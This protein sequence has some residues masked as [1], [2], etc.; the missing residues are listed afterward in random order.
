MRRTDA[1]RGRDLSPVLADRRHPR[2]SG[3]ERRRSTSI[4]SLDHPSPAPS[5]Q[6]EIHFTY[7][8]HQAATA[9]QNVPGQ[10]NRI[11]AVR[12]AR[13]KFAIYFD[14]DG[15]APTEY[16]IY[17]LERDPNEAT[18]WSIGPAASR[19]T[20][21]IGAAPGAGRAARPAHVGERHRLAARSSSL[22]ASLCEPRRVLGAEGVHRLPA[23][24][25]L[26]QQRPPRRAGAKG[27]GDLEQQALSNTAEAKSSDKG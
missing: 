3:C 27:R 4:R 17:D 19:S 8:D 24:D 9:L 26:A 10:P 6:E 12:T 25:Q 22:R 20:A 16:E 2:A 23:L 14:P 18:T 5:V 7:D 11:R 1:V 15:K 21:P 13:H